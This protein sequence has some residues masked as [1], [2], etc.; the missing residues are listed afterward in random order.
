MVFLVEASDR[1]R[2]PVNYWDTIIEFV[3]SVVDK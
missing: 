3:K 1:V 2:S